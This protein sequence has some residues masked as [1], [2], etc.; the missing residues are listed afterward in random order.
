MITTLYRRIGED[1][2][3]S[4][5]RNHTPDAGGEWLFLAWTSAR[6]DHGAWRLATGLDEVGVRIGASY[7]DGQVDYYLWRPA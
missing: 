1:D 4:D 7:T 2:V 5:G 3:S 6:T